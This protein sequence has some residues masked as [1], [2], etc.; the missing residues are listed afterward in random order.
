ML[1]RRLYT[2][3]VVRYVLYSNAS[4]DARTT[5]L[6]YARKTDKTGQSTDKTGQSTDKTG[7]STDK[8]GTVYRQDKDSLQTS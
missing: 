6:D 4:D 7:L 1:L 3:T 5:A 8:I 2:R